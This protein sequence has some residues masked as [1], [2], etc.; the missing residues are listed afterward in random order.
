MK[1]KKQ[2]FFVHW[3]QNNIVLTNKQKGLSWD[4]TVCSMKQLL[5]YV[6]GWS[7]WV[8]MNKISMLQPCLSTTFLQQ[9]VATEG[10]CLFATVHSQVT[11]GSWSM[12]YKY[13]LLHQFAWFVAHRMFYL[14]V[15]HHCRAKWRLKKFQFGIVCLRSYWVLV[16]QVSCSLSATAACSI[17]R[18]E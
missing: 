16:L 14:F 15:W 13:K 11:I 2:L 18:Y 5:P 4:L 12:E 1:S 10:I 3:E 9:P 7:L 6:H 8:A 17:P